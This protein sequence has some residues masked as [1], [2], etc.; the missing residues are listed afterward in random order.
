MNAS[1]ACAAG[2]MSE[3]RVVIVFARLPQLGRVKSRLAAALGEATALAIYRELLDDTLARVA[4][5]ASVERW[6]CVTGDDP[7][8]H[9]EALARSRGYRL[10]RQIDGDLGARMAASLREALAGGARALLLG[11]DCPGIDARVLDQAFEALARHD[12]VFV[13]T[14]DGGY[15]L[16]GASVDAPA[17]FESIAWGGSGVMA[18]TRVRL[19][20]L[21]LS[22]HE[23]PTLWDVDEP[24]DW[25]RV[26]RARRAS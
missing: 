5:C 10:T 21:G 20:R 4:G 1:Q 6:L 9:G 12:L 8:G 14:E 24:Q 22:W 13:P 15:A 2:G 18:Q 16:V 23:L 17:V 3:R 26:L 11:C 25:Q 19:A 7:E